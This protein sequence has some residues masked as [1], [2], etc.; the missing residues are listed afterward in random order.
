MRSLGSKQKEEKL[1]KSRETNAYS[2]YGK[3]A[4]YAIFNLEENEK[5]KTKFIQT[6][7]GMVRTSHEYRNFLN[8]LKQEA[9]LTYCSILNGLKDEDLK[10]ISLE[11]HHYPYTLYDITEAVINRHLMNQLDFTRLSIANEV[12]NLH[13]MLQVGLVPLTLTMHQMAHTGNILID[14]EHV[15]GDYKQ[16][17]K[18]YDLY[19][20]EDAKGRYMH[21]FT[22][23]KNKEL[24]KQYNMDKLT[25]NP[26]LFQLEDRTEEEPNDELEEDF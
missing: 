17:S 14:M 16:F 3:P 18:D 25:I 10:D 8:Y 26:K 4:F 19:L 9:Q 11:I 7:E 24:I 1:P 15:F 22:R 12:M 20:S 6:V 5:N 23:N 13:Y 21:Y 2:L